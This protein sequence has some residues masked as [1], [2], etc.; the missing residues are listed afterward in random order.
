MMI[1]TKIEESF[2]VAKILKHKK[3]ILCRAQLDLFLYCANFAEKPD[4]RKGGY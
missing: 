1:I 2:Y 3:M 4:F